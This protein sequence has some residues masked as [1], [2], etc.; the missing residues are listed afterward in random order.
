[1]GSGVGRHG[2][3]APSW[4]KE[5][6][7]SKEDGRTNSGIQRELTEGGSVSLVPANKKL[8]VGLGS[9][10][11]GGSV[12]NKTDGDKGVGRGGLVVDRLEFEA[13]GS[14]GGRVDKKNGV[15]ELFMGGKEVVQGGKKGVLDADKLNRKRY[16]K[17]ERDGK[18]VEQ[19]GEKVD[20]GKKRSGEDMDADVHGKEKKP[21]DSDVVMNQNQNIE[22][23]L[24]EQPCGTQ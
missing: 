9:A 20:V 21:K 15:G 12:E 17:V 1:L 18:R 5:D 11:N 10:K 19:V 13:E 22:A 7:R 8:H 2:S 3:D 6:P 4:R 16:K 23:G 14:G 24:S